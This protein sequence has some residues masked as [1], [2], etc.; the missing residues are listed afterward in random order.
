MKI[1]HV[2]IWTKQLEALKNF[3]CRYFGAKA[4]D[5]YINNSNGFES[6]FLSFD[7]GCRLE[8]MQMDSILESKNNLAYQYV[9]LIH[10]AISVGDKVKVISL[11]EQLKIDGVEILSEPRTTGDGYFESIVMDP[12]GNR[13]EITI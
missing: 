11:T 4:N 6:Y 8:L 13:I 1:E 2:A 5:K 10:I 3:Y 7:S 12:D 9:G